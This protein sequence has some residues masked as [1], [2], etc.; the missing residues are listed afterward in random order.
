[1]DNINEIWKEVKGYEGLYWVSNLARLKNRF[2]NITNGYSHNKLGYKKFRLYKDGI[3]KDL[4][5]HRVVA[6]NFINNTDNK[7]I[8]NHIDSNPSNN[9]VTN[10]EWC[11]QKENMTHASKNN[12]LNSKGVKILDKKTGIIY[13][14]IKLAAEANNILPNTLQYTIYRDKK[15]KSN[16]AKVH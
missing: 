12:R 5:V 3:K 1:M 2:G 15:N 7:P 14:S 9:I 4:F 11:T 6:L 8:V 16:F 10:L 13:D